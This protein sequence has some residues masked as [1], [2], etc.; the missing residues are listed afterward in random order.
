MNENFNKVIAEV[1]EFAQKH[2]RPIASEMDNKKVFP[3][4]LIKKMAERGFLSASFPLKYNGL[5]MDPVQYGLFTEEIGKACCSTRTLITIQTSLIGESILRYGTKEQK[6]YW[7]TKISKGEKLGAFC[8]SEPTHG[9]DAKNIQTRYKREREKIFITGKKKWISFAGIADFFIVLATSNQGYTTAFIVDRY[10]KGI[11]VNEIDG[12]FASRATHIAE[13]E[14]NNVEVPEE[15]ILGNEGSGFTFIVSTALDHGRYSVA[16]GGVGLAQEA[17]EVMTSYAKNRVQF[18]TA[19]HNHQLVQGMI[20][21]SVTSLHA[22]RALCLK[23]GE[24][25]KKNDIDAINET[26]FAKYFS[27]KVAMKI[28]TDAVQVLGANGCLN[29]YPTERLFR[30]AKVL[31]IIEGTSQLQQ[32][33]AAN[34]AL[35]N[36]ASY[37]L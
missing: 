17:L 6:D 18:D 24:M 13:I 9:S 20:G 36:Y 7:L 10:S 29:T 11:K 4:S 16:W 25:R 26:N 23:A 37:K 21:D 3:K 8:L 30:E 5:E 27:S 32:L 12:I 22:A 35:Y 28:A 14:F 33:F 15:N 34:Y 19:I 31:E 2:I 1:K